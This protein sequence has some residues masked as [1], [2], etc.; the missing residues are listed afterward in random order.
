MEK[1]LVPGE[2][3]RHYKGGIYRIVDE[4]INAENDEH[5]VIYENEAGERFTRGIYDFFSQVN[6]W[7]N[8]YST[9]R[10]VWI[11]N[12][13]NDTV[14]ID[15]E[16]L[17][18]KEA[19]INWWGDLSLATGPRPEKEVPKDTI[20]TE[21]GEEFEVK[22]GMVDFSEN[23][24]KFKL[25]DFSFPDK[26]ELLEAAKDL[27]KIN[28]EFE[29]EGKRVQDILEE[30]REKASSIYVKK[31]TPDTQ[32]FVPTKVIEARVLLQGDIDGV[33]DYIGHI[34]QRYYILAPKKEG[35]RVKR[36]FGIPGEDYL[37]L[38]EGFAKI[39]SKE[40]F[41]AKYKHEIP[42]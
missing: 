27:N 16:K 6:I 35:G 17:L 42:F 22:F 21:D 30:Q 19:Q 3:Y 26:K 33:C 32:N 23:G 25:S 39:V 2:L 36:Q 20:K 24:A 34:D 5:T 29:L 13:K 41:E 10:F 38:G 18:V 1:R 8:E 37:I 9:V 31:E 11:E 7:G 40:K 28:Q 15:G 4:C 12:A 14:N